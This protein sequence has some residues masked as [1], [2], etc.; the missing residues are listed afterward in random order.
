MVQFES[1]SVYLTG[2]TG[3]EGGGGSGAHL[4][5]RQQKHMAKAVANM[6]ISRGVANTART[7]V[8]NL[9]SADAL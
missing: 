7:V 9:P 3:G 4:S 6:V 2:E 5:S 1:V 8:L